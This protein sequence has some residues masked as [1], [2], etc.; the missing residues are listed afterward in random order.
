[1]KYEFHYQ[2][3]DEIRTI[4]L[5]EMD[6]R[7]QAQ[8]N[9][10]T[11]TLAIIDNEPGRLLVEVNGRRALAYTALDDKNVR[12]HVNGANWFLRRAA[13]GKRRRHT[14]ADGGS[15][16]AAMPGRILDVLAVPGDV[17]QK[18]DTLALL[19]AMKMEL[20]IVAPAA[21]RVQAVHCRAGQVV[22]RG[23]LL[24]ELES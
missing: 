24:V 19:E 23:Q 2:V 10:R 12:L 22:E 3:E 16:T 18:G 6:G 8:V 14:A 15:L 1:M 21:G 13:P 5:E 17:V 9:G 11:L 20:R 4:V 7:W